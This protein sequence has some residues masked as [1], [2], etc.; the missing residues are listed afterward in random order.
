MRV[1]G[2]WFEGSLKDAEMLRPMM[3][4][5]SGL[6]FSREAVDIAMVSPRQIFAAV[7]EEPALVRF[8]PADPEGAREVTLLVDPERL[9]AGVADARSR[10]RE[11]GAS[12]RGRRGDRGRKQL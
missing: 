12:R 4:P 5:R 9:G 11:P 2:K 8:D 6:P 1:G 7:D 10:R 3:D